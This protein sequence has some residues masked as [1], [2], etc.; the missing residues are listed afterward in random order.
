MIIGMMIVAPYHLVRS[1][2]G[3]LIDEIPLPSVTLCG[4]DNWLCIWTVR[5]RS[6]FCWTEQVFHLKSPT[7]QISESERRRT[8]TRRT[9]MIDDSCA[10]LIIPVT[11]K[12]NINSWPTSSLLGTLVCVY[13]ASRGLAVCFTSLLLL[14]LVLPREKQPKR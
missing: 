6:L 14:I 4:L 12:I 7:H 8:S 1:S 3:M 9:G 10:K 11:I 13:G 2:L 5:L